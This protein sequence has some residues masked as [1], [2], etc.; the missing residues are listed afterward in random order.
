MLIQKVPRRF[1]APTVQGL[2]VSFKSKGPTRRFACSGWPFLC[3]ACN[4]PSF[5]E[6]TKK[7]PTIVILSLVS[8]LRKTRDTRR[9]NRSID[10]SCYLLFCM[11]SF[12]LFLRI[13][14]ALSV[15]K[16]TYFLLVG[17][18]D[19]NRRVTKGGHESKT[20]FLI[21]GL[22]SFSKREDKML[23]QRSK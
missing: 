9:E 4:V 13:E 18:S 23:L 7:G 1:A 20:L 17:T 11:R 10:K 5:A 8:L 6:H 19:K 12:Y 21:K 16:K 15:G 2:F 22:I 3:A 14:S